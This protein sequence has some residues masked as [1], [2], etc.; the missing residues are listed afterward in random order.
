MT[1]LKQMYTSPGSAHLP[2]LATKA[3]QTTNE[4]QVQQGLMIIIV[5]WTQLNL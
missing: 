3:E 4:N 1:A 5:L 2:A